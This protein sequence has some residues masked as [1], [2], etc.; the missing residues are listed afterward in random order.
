MQHF[1]LRPSRYLAA[2]LVM[3]HG[4]AL[5]ALFPLALPAWTK[6]ALSLVILISLIYHSR[7]DAMLTSGMAVTA[8]L[9]EQDKVV[10]TLRDGGQLT[11]QMLRDSLVTPCL[12]VLNI[13]PQG[14]RLARS[15]VILPDSLDAES[16][17]QLRVRLKLGS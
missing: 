10:L 14:A 9:L 2:L 5:A 4:A 13:L 3:A 12:V 11:G 1:K 6:A 7:R 15:V 8:L 16:F 17:R